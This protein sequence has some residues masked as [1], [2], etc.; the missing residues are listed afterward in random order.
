MHMVS[1]RTISMA[2]RIGGLGVRQARLTNVSMLGKLVW[3]LA[4]NSDKLWAHILMSYY[5]HDEPF[6]HSASRRGS[7]LRN[8]LVKARNL[9][10]P[11]FVCRVGECELSFWFDHSCEGGPLC[12]LVPYVHV[13]DTALRIKDVFRDGECDLRCLSTPLTPDVRQ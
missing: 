13:S 1:W 6:L 12:S 9:I 2:K 7:P 3:E 4:H 8:A 5:C 10:Q 11:G